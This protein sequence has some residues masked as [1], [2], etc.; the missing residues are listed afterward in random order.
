MLRDG[1][2]SLFKSKEKSVDFT[3]NP[4]DSENDLIAPFWCDI[5]TGTATNITY[6][7]TT[8]LGQLFKADFSV[9]TAFRDKDFRSDEL[10]ISTWSNALAV[11]GNLAQVC[12]TVCS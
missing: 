5:A 8:S 7:T 3:L 9:N 11:G 12:I 6:G 4:F 2:I 1:G 10:F